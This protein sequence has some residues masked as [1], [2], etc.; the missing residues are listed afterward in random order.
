MSTLTYFIR[1]YS[2]FTPIPFILVSIS[3]SSWWNVVNNALSD[4]GHPSNSVGAI[5]FNLGLV[6]GGYL[7]AIQSVLISKYVKLLESSLI[8]MIG[9]SLILVGTINESFG[10]AHFVVSVILFTVLATYITYSMI[11]YRIPWLAAGLI[12]STLLWYTHLTLN[13]PKGAA[14]PE[15][16]S[17][18]ITYVTYITC[19]F[20]KVR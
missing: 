18:I 8:S 16:V 3:V 17:I 6:L 11:A 12:I 7:M 20:Q 10:Y 13:I 19:T 1:V 5:I 9:L 14:L 2:P 4:L 15:L